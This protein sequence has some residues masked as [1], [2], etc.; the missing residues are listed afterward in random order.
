MTYK[1]SYPQKWDKNGYHYTQLVTLR[2][3]YRQS[4]LTNAFLAE[5][6]KLFEDEK[7]Y[8]KE[9]K[10]YFFSLAENKMLAQFLG[11]WKDPRFLPNRNTCVRLITIL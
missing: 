3:T 6:G 8:D 9:Q 10:L 5:R 2:M 11:Y 4:C 7:K 1:I